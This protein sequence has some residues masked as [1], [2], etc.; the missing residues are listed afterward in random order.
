M[1]KRCILGYPKCAQ[2]RVR[3]NCA[4]AQSDLNLCWAHMSEGSF[5][6]AAVDM[7]K[8]EFLKSVQIAIICSP[9]N[10]CE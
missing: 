1:R 9:T 3:F 2:R 7:V 6:H 8:L 10:V 4:N 5:S